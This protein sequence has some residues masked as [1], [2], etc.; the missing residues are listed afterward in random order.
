MKKLL[1]IVVTLF[2]TFLSAQNTATLTGLIRDK[3][4]DLE[5]LPF[6]SVFVEGTTN[7][8][9]TDF[10]GNYT[11]KLKPGTYTVVYEFVGYK[12]EKK[13]ISVVA[14]KNNQ[15]LDLVSAADV[16]DAVVITAVVSK[17]SEEALIEVQK[18]AVEIK[19]SI[20]AEELSKKGVSDVATAVTKAAGI[21]K[22]EGGANSGGVFVRGLGDR[23]NV[24]TLNGLPLPSNNPANKNISLDIFS[25]D[26]VEYVGISKTFEVKNYAD[27][28]GANID[29]NSKK[30]SGESFVSLGLGVSTNTNV[31]DLNDFYLQDGPSSSGF[32]VTKAPSDFT[33]V[34]TYQTS[35]DRQSKNYRYLPNFSLS[36]GKSFKS[37]IGDFDVFV[38][39]SFDSDSKYQEGL[40][41]GRVTG[42]GFIKTDYSRKSYQ[43]NTTSTVLGTVN[44]E[45]NPG[46][47]IL[48]TTLFLNSTSQD[49]SEYNGNNDDFDGGL[50]DS[51]ESSTFGFTKRGTFDKTKVIVNQLTGNN[52]VNEQLGFKWAVGY[53]LL[54]NEI[55]DRLQNTIINERINDISEDRGRFTLFTN[56]AV[57]N[58][59]YYQNLDEGELSAYFSTAYEFNDS[60]IDT[61]FGFKDKINFGLSLRL[62][63]VDFESD[64]YGF[65]PEFDPIIENINETDRI[66]VVENFLAND[67]EVIQNSYEGQQN[68]LS[69]YASLEHRFNPKLTAIIGARA[70]SVTQNVSYITEIIPQGSKSNSSFFEILPSITSRYKINDN[71]NL[72]LALSKTYTLP[73]FKEKV[74]LLYEEVT[75]GYIGNRDLYQSTNYNADLGWE[76]FPEGKKGE[77][78]S[79]TTFGKVIQNP[80]NAVFVNSASGDISYVNSGEAAKVFGVE[81]EI[82]KNIFDITTDDLLNNRLS[83]GV[84]FSYINHTQDLDNE[85]VSRENNIAVSFTTDES[86][87]S[88]A[89]DILANADLSY[90]KEFTE[91]FNITS[92]LSYSH[93]SDKLAII[94]TNGRGNIIEKSI[95]KLDLIFKSN[96]SKR[97]KIGLS[98]KNILNPEFRSVQEQSKV[99]NDENS[100]V[101]ISSFKRGIGASLS[102]GYK[103]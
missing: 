62:K 83:A 41:R 22:S 63:Q 11:M 55:P 50:N 44:Y 2:T 86:K 68:I 90:Y 78:F 21:S 45:M 56:G 12:T 100:D 4:A 102:L 27:F 49:Y 43:Y 16:L 19:T 31:I 84:N 71:N 60:K 18:E 76:F 36:G 15:S 34:D 39:A 52:N 14:G 37:K 80:I 72:K 73:Q 48:L 23:Y 24:T 33:N 46:N 88:G 9:T 97:L 7:G 54:N 53:S 74:E 29:I 99:G 6:V 101:V 51:V 69:A 13:T 75:Q 3:D 94:G 93:F 25:T 89:S 66:F 67:V 65:V 28:A 81:L 10:F 58:S 40:N 64:L 32:K 79:L 35:W 38:T 20:G 59:R 42:S 103:F 70:E 95:D 1:L 61:D 17:E 91:G 96:L 57:N 98:I 5:P 85:K 92:T 30:H 8:T 82:R 87:L 26:I 77:L 47:S